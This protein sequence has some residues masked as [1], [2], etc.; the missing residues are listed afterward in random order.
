MSAAVEELGRRAREAA[1]RVALAST[2]EKNLALLTAADLLV[3]RTAEILEANARDVAAA[4]ADGMAASAI[5]RLR[6]TDARI[7]GMAGGLRQVASLADPVGEVL[8]ETRLP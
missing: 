3:E 6:L 4:E 1:R 5:D 2:D 7:G 8:D